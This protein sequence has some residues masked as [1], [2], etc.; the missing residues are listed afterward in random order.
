MCGRA[1]DGARAHNVA[2]RGIER[3]RACRSVQ[4]VCADIGVDPSHYG[5]E[6]AKRVGCTPSQMTRWQRVAQAAHML[7]AT[8]RP[9]AQVAIEAGYCDQSHMCREMQRVLGRTPRAIRASAS[10][11]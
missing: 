8:A 11:S 6:F 9:L 1:V 3:S 4:S 7:R 10:D 5:R 2:A